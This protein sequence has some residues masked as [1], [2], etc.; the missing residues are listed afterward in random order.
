MA[1]AVAVVLLLLFA[2]ARLA[3]LAVLL[4]SVVAILLLLPAAENTDLYKKRFSVT[5]T[6]DLREAI[7]DVSLALVAQ[8]PIVGW[9]YDSFDE[10]KNASELVAGQPVPIASVLQTT[11]HNSYLTILVELGA[12]ATT[13]RPS[14]RNP[15]HPWTQTA[16][17][18]TRAGSSRSRSAPS[19]SSP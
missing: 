16:R 6:I 3:G 2:R 4:A 5:S 11:S 13:V 10:V 19:S 17:V 1:T 15:L 12:I 9:G 8:K 18:P 7:Q 14:I